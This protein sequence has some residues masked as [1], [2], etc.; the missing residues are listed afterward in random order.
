MIYLDGQYVH[1]GNLS[2][3]VA[4]YK[5]LMYSAENLSPTWH[6]LTIL[7]TDP[8]DKKYT[9]ID[10]VSLTTTMNSE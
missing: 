6:N 7:N 1:T 9:G 3:P 2:D 8:G 5:E 4:S 10:F